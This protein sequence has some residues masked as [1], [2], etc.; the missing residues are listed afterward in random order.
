MDHSQMDGTTDIQLS[1][2][3]EVH[4][5]LEAASIPHWLDG[6]WGL[7]F[8]LGRVGRP[9]SDI[10]W[11]IWKS[12]AAKVG[13]LLEA[14]G[15]RSQKVRHPEEH[16]GFWRF[17]QYVSFTLNEINSG[18]KTVTSGRWRDWPY[19]EGAFSGEPGRI[20]ALVCPIVS[21]EAQLDVREN[22]HKHP[23]G[24]PLREIDHRAI[25]E[26]RKLIAQNK[27]IGDK[28]SS[29]RKGGERYKL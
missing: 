23:A 1:I 16:I 18:G 29:L 22:F 24:A 15:Y 17:E 3:S 26:L 2:I 25:T 4:E 21:A 7:D 28:E 6:G 13:K 10:D 19:P 9:N 20:G 14:Q 5:L 27:P 11:L 12:D 8:L